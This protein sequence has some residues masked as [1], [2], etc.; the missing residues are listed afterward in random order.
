[1][2]VLNPLIQAAAAQI[3]AAGRGQR[4]KIIAELARQLGVSE[5]TARSRLEPYLPQTT[6][7]RRADA[8]QMSLSEREAKIISAYIRASI[9][10]TGTGEASIM[11]AVKHLRAAGEIL[12]G[13]VDDDTGEVHHLSESA[14]ARAMR[15]Y[16]VH[17]SQIQRET[18]ATRMSSPNPN[19][20]WQIDASVSRQF[21]LADN[22]TEV[23]TRQRFYRGKPAN[24]VAIDRM[25]VWRYAITDHASGAIEV[26]YVLGAESA[27]N[28]L[29]ALIHVMAY[30]AKGTMHGVPKYLKMDP[31]SAPKSGPV[32]NF[33]EPLGIDILSNEAGNSRANGQV[34]NAH[35][36]IERNF[37]SA[38]KFIPPLC[39]IAEF[40]E[41]AAS[42]A[43]DY[44]AT[45]VHSRTGMTRRD[46]WLRITP[47]QLVVAPAAD[48]L[49]SL[50]NSDPVECT[51]RDWMIRFKG[52][53]YD[54]R[55]LDG[56]LNGGKVSVVRNA[57]DNGQSVRVL[58]KDAEGR[59][60]H[61]IAPLIGR[62]D[63]GFLDT[64]AQVG[65]EHKAVPDTAADTMRKEL[66]R[67]AMGA[68][69]DEEAEKKRK[70]KAVPFGGQIKPQLAWD[71][72]AT[73]IPRAIRRAGTK[74]AV[75]APAVADAVAPAP[76]APAY[77]A[78]VYNGFELVKLL[79]IRVEDRG[80]TWRTEWWDE[81]ARR[82][83]N[84][85]TDE[86]LDAAVT[87]LLQPSLRAIS[88]GAA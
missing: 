20:C 44:N 26:V 62:S 47:E 87:Q 10:E 56:V 73:Q 68:A 49:R 24:F 51:V 79:K 81:I 80:Q 75:E 6:R 71:Q 18:P 34:E 57:L 46:G 43:Y 63:F 30:R 7:K 2:T 48:V 36:L 11:L 64:A 3:V 72:A 15:A 54:L 19:W 27:A 50:A 39:S 59:T 40:N 42:W 74:S 58:T 1:M 21:Y 29:T 78:P 8:G 12:A 31:G 70:A 38:L 69:T 85:L 65:T 22:G 35:N 23:M 61:F 60:A 33:C 55:G 16:G 41:L 52:E 17:P 86:A 14:I 84:G 82:W 32:R 25:R 4:G 83:P 13:R 77:E 45:R 37:E 9:R 53:R 5:Q 67:L 66:D 76:K 88:G 28:L